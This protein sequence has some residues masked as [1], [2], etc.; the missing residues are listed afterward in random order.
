MVHIDTLTYLYFENNLNLFTVFFDSFGH[1]P[2]SQFVLAWAPSP[3]EPRSLL[4]P[5]RV[6]LSMPALGWH[7]QPGRSR[8]SA[9]PWPCLPKLEDIEAGTWHWDTDGLWI[10]QH[11]HHVT[12]CTNVSLHVM[13]TGLYLPPVQRVFPLDAHWIVRARVD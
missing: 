1:V 11:Q 5:K 10:Y 12:I 6:K 2:S 8:I 3:V 7:K 13:I 4:W 9:G